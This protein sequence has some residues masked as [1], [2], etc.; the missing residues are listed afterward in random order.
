MKVK[1]IIKE[2]STYDP[3]ANFC[4]VEPEDDRA[5]GFEIGFDKYQN[6]LCLYIVNDEYDEDVWD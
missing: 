5:V 4:I 1:E 3:E 2:L 6:C